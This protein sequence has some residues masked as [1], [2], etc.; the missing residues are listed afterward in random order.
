MFN[1]IQ[2]QTMKTLKKITV[3]LAILSFFAYQ[4]FSQNTSTANTPKD[5][6]ATQ[7]ATSPA[8]GKFVD[9]NKDGVCDNHQAKMKS[10]K[11]TNFADKNGDGICD[12]RQNAGQGKGNCNGC[13]MGCKQKQGQGNGNGCG[14]GCGNQHRHGCGNQ[15]TPVADPQ[16]P[17]N[18]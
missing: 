7:S 8:P 9:A 18:K 10:G 1:R 3:L 11:C 4:G 12:N 17:N 13:G 16:K 2:N 5:S 14:N 6:Q 15:N